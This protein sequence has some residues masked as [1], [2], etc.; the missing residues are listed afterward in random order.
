M[1][2]IGKLN[3]VIRVDI[4]YSKRSKKFQKVRSLQ[5]L[6][7]A[8]DTSRSKQNWW[9]SCIFH[10]IPASQSTKAT[11]MDPKGLRKARMELG[12]V[13]GFR[14]IVNA[15]RNGDTQTTSKLFQCRTKNS[16][17]GSRWHKV[18]SSKT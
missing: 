5:C 6:L 16:H 7:Y 1:Y 3:A 11:N 13:G 12:M 14:K 4:V 8:K 10:R 18:N 15:V 2:G 17:D 9:N